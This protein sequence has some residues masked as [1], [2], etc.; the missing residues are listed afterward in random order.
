MFKKHSCTY[1]GERADGRDHVVPF[2]A[3][4]NQFKSFR[5]NQLVPCCKECNST[6]N[7]KGDLNGRYTIGTKADYLLEKYTEK[8]NSFIVGRRG[9]EDD[10]DDYSGN[11]KVMMEQD[12]KMRRIIK[13]R[14][15]WLEIVGRIDPT[16]EDVWEEIKI[17]EGEMEDEGLKEVY[18]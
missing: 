11:L 3:I 1:C 12:M 18:E 5:R 6:L 10:L 16:V 14:V 8:Y 4:P 13:D 17:D 2:S 7:N 9:E 15:I